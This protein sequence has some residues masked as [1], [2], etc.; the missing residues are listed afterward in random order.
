MSLWQALFLGLLQGATELFPVS[1]LGHAVLLP[2]LLGW[3]YNESDPAFVPYIVLLH[4]GTATALLIVFREDWGRLVRA[5][6]ASVAR[7]RIEG[8]DQRLALMLFVATIPTG[9][10]GVFFESDLKRL[11]A[12]PRLAAAFLCLNGLIM[13]AGEVM[14]R[15]DE[16]RRHAEVGAGREAAFA[17]E[18]ELGWIPAVII[19]TSQSLALLPGISRSG[20]TITAGLV[21]GL[22]HQAA[23]RFSFL[24]ATPVI[25]A[26]GVLEVP[27]L[28]SAGSR[29]PVYLAGGVVAGITAYLSTRFLLRYFRTGRLDPFAAYCLGLGLLGLVAAR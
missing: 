17:G 7:G 10:L 19:G 2:R 25:L 26:A 11:F 9:L 27:S 23:A 28:A 14:R 6:L 1:S 4:L 21:A 15:R 16:R 29:L 18:R 13:G 8:P 22:R 12:T 20:S 5:F 3:S 24:L